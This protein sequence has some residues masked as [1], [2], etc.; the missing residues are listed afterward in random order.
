MRSTVSIGAINTAS[1]HPSETSQQS[2]ALDE[3]GVPI[4]WQRGELLD[5]RRYVDGSFT[6]ATLSGKS[7]KME[8][9]SAESAQAFVSYWYAPI[10]A[11][12]AE[13]GGTAQDLR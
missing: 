11:R 12:E 6:A 5:V 2:S 8:F 9:D 13:R 1:G 3:N 10:S 4:D 7:G